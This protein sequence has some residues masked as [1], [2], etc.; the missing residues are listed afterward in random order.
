[1]FIIAAMGYI[2]PEYCFEGYCSPSTGL[3]FTN[4]PNGLGAL[5]KVPVAGWCQWF[6]FCGFFLIYAA[7]AGPEGR[8]PQ[9]LRQG[10]GIPRAT[11][12]NLGLLRA[13]G[14]GDPAK[15]KR[16]LNSELANGRL[17]MFAIMGMMFQNGVTSTTGPE[18]WAPPAVFEQEFGVQALVGLDP[19]CFSKDGDVTKFKRR[20][21]VELKHGRVAM[22]AAMGYI[23]WST[24]SLPRAAVVVCQVE[25]C[26]HA[27]WVGG[28]IQDADGGWPLV[29][30]LLRCL[31]ARILQAKGEPGSRRLRKA[32]NLGFP[33]LRAFRAL[34]P[35]SIA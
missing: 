28:A 8:P 30:L 6:L 1:V 29:I 25:V 11:Y 33:C 27:A 5:S 4:I 15:R 34:M 20:R 35:S 31:G 32:W 3:R 22:L 14:I 21:K 23:I 7:K 9:A 24:F 13:D 19:L 10:S 2:T 17:A 12:G 18:M 16:G 26:R